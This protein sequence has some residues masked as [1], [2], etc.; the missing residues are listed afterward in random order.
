ME[1]NSATDHSDKEIDFVMITSVQLMGSGLY[2]QVGHLAVELV[3]M[4]EPAREHVCVILPNQRL[5]VH[6][7]RALASNYRNAITQIRAQLMACGV[8]G[9][10]GQLAVRL[11]AKESKRGH[12]YVTILNQRTTGHSV[13]EMAYRNKYATLQLLAKRRVYGPVG[14]LVAKL[15]VGGCKKGNDS[16]TTQNKKT[17]EHQARSLKQTIERVL[18]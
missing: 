11:V 12:E 2:G 9:Q 14:L 8:P 7:A 15:V 18:L 13:L 17:M 4:E 5:M 1:G 6:T 16:T 10:L 3:V